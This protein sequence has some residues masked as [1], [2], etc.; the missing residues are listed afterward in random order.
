MAT[1]KI[2][3]T[4]GSGKNIATH[5]ISEDALTKELQRVVPST[6]AGAE[7]LPATA[8]QIGE[9][10]ASPTA[11]TLLDR[12]KALLTGIV[13]AAGSAIIGKVGIDQTTP[14]T[15]N[16]VSIG[17]DGTVGVTGSVAVTNAG[18]TT[19]AGAVAGTEMQVD[20]LTMPTVTV[21]SHAVTN[22]GTFAVQVD[23]CSLPT[24]AATAA[25]QLPD[26][27]SVA[28]SATDNAVLD[29]IA[30]SDA[31]IDGKIT[32]CN[33][34]AVVISS[35]S[36]TVDLGANN[37][38]TVTNATAANLKCE[39]AS[40]SAIKTAVE[41]IDNA[42]SG[43]EMQVDVVAA[44]PA[45]TNIIGAVKRDVINYT[46]IRKYIAGA[47]AQT[48]T[49]VWSPA[50]GKKW[51]ITDLICSLSAAGTITFEE[52]KTGGDEVVFAL[53]WAANGGVS[54]NLQTPIFGTEDDADL[55]VTTTAG[56]VKIFVL[57]YEID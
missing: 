20:V 35:G 11:N 15:T 37:D 18:I 31:S 10:Q 4:E 44:L 57:G 21:N 54:S 26:G 3:A 24:G 56:N 27:H 5:S 22:A 34:G 14:G 50:A 30:A 17:T 45:G 39:E 52:D 33:T 23:S 7:I 13:L 8:A 2:S 55:I 36:C 43:S 41:L 28:L 32:A 29:A 6:S 42:I 19:I 1:S 40:A 25:K 49:I 16:K 48:D 51:V 12:V 38:V 46:P 9:V 47:G 53:D